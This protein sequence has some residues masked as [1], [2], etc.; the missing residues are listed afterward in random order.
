MLNN[1]HSEADNLGQLARNDFLDLC[2]LGE[3]GTCKTRTARLIQI[4]EPRDRDLRINRLG[5]IKK[6]KRL[7]H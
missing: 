7:G 2:L 1:F 3:T 5:L 4:T 6:L